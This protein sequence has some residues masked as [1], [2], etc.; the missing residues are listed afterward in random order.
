MKYQTQFHAGT[1]V[2]ITAT[3]EAK[4]YDEAEKVFRETLHLAL[5]MP[6]AFDWR[7]TPAE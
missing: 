6:D 4:D 1:A 2:Q 5:G 7:D 3:V